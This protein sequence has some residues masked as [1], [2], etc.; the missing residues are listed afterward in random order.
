MRAR[1]ETRTQD[2]DR[3]MRLDLTQ[4]VFLKRYQRFLADVRLA[5]GSVVT[6]HCPNSGSMRSLLTPEMPCWLAHHDNPKRKLAWTLTL[7]GLPG[8]GIAVVDTMLPNRVVEEGIRTGRIPELAGYA[9]LRREVAYGTRRSR[10]DLLLEDPQRPPC[11][12]EVKNNTMASNLARDRGDFPDAVTAR[13]AKHLAE[14]ADRALAGERA[15]MVYLVGR[16]DVR[17]AGIAEDIDPG[18]ATAL[19]TA[20]TAGVE[21]LCYRARLSP[22]S[23]T[24]DRRLPFDF[25]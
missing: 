24:I 16:S 11:W 13:G 6:V 18:Y 14:L 19:R 2:P 5:D 3:T 9:S 20:L 25:D 21:V 12:V 1:R 15:V 4:A 17:S 23:I 7:L 10:I 22:R 8:G